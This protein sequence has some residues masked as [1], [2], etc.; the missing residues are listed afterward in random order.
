MSK[1]S[2]EQPTT[3]NPRLKPFGVL[4]GTWKTVGTHPYLPDIT[5]H[6]HTSFEWFEGG[7]FLIMRSELDSSQFPKGVAIFGSDD[8]K[9]EFF[10]LYFDDR[11]VSRKYKVSLSGNVLKW[12][13]DDPDFSQR[14]T[15]EISADNNSIVSKGEMSK[16][17][18][19][20]EK[21]LDLIYTRVR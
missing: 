14:V 15:A 17:K 7:A 13:R 3:F 21:D 5:L 4:V 18:S 8:A 1:N 11:G 6:G 20:W 16:N 19:A 12:W 2:K 10:K 9:G